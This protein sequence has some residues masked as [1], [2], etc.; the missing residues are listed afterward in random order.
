MH[1]YKEGQRVKIRANVTEEEIEEYGALG[2]KGVIYTIDEPGESFDG[3][4]IYRLKGSN[5][6]YEDWLVSVSNNVIGGE[7][8]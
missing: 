8:L 7:I 3:Y 1:K 4:L 2:K 6:H 5:W